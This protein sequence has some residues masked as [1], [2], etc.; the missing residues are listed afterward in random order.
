MGLL[1]KLFCL[2]RL[3]GVLA[4]SFIGM[5]FLLAAP[6]LQLV[7]D[8]AEP[9]GNNS[10]Y[11]QGAG[12][13]GFWFQLGVLQGIRNLHEHHYYCY[14]SGC[15]SILMALTNTS[16]D[17]ALSSTFGVQHA[18]QSGNISRYEIV[19]RF[20]DDILSVDDNVLSEA[21]DRMNILV[22]TA[23]EGL[24]IGK[25]KSPLELRDL[26]IKTTYIPYITGWGAWLNDEFGGMH[27]DGGFSRALH[28]RCEYTVDIPVT[29]LNI[30]IN[31]FNPGLDRES[32]HKF[33]LQ[34]K[35]H[36]HPLH[37]L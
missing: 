36:G 21:V 27:L 26:L 32:V 19:N 9:A 28:P 1:W 11:I 37:R 24:T 20:V 3:I 25:A 31:T 15:L 17:D 6:P 13:S 4:V 10:V 35:A 23:K 7:Y 8:V 29:N 5:Y 18:W 30:G 34:G 12:F 2:C 33:W 16:I 14:S 22:T